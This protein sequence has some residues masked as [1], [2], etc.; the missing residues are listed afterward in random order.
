PPDMIKEMIPV[1]NPDAQFETIQGADHFYWVKNGDIK[2]I[3]Q[4]FLE[5]DV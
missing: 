5:R 3:I 4:E 2:R 1:W